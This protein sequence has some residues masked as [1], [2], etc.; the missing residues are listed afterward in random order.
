M[1]R[2][3]NHLRCGLAVVLGLGLIQ[4]VHA[5]NVCGAVAQPELQFGL[6]ADEGLAYEKCR[7]VNPPIAIYGRDRTAY[8]YR[9]SCFRDGASRSFRL[10][11]IT[12]YLDP[13]T[14]TYVGAPSAVISFYGYSWP[15]GQTCATRPQKAL[16]WEGGDDVL[17][18]DGG[19]EM[20]NVGFGT[21]TAC[22]WSTVDGR[23]FY[24]CAGTVGPTGKVCEAGPPTT[25]PT[26][27][28]PEPLPP[29]PPP[30]SPEPPPTPPPSP[31]PPPPSPQ[32]PPSPPPSPP[33]SGSGDGQLVVDGLGP[34][35]DAIEQAVLG[36]GPRIDSVRASIDGA[37]AGASGDA[38]RIIA[39]I[40][41]QGEG[42]GDGPLDLSPLTPGDDG[43]PHPV[44]GDVVERGTAAEM[45]GELD[46]D[47]W[48]LTRSC[49]AMAWPQ[50]FE[51]GWGVVSMSESLNLVCAALAILGWVI[52]LCGLV[53]ASF[54]LSRVGGGS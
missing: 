38:D 33:G 17:L 3:R 41:A 37:R 34:R 50:S 18:C 47:G 29:P 2:F 5:Q 20:T 8:E 35:L 43:G 36:L 26:P 30:P 19:C 32:P 45:L 54:I 42:E 4:Q 23:R 28:D 10:D 22:S 31:E 48:R 21:V 40:N 49:P 7:T 51:L 52:G 14:C 15:E 27:P 46:T 53:Q 24:R 13:S 1:D 11:I 9:Q 44:L 16:S 39:A 25:S 6:Y 12:Q